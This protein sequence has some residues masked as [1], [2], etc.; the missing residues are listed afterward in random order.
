MITAIDTSVL[1]DVFL[2]DRK[3]VDG[4][5]RAIEMAA[6]D[7]LLVASGVVWAEVSAVFPEP[8]RAD[9][10]L[11]QAG[12]SYSPMGRHAALRA[13]AS[14]R[15][16]RQAGGTRN[17][18]IADFLIAGHAIENADRLLTRDRGFHRRYFAELVVLAP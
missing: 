18:M 14:W 3:F 1:L 13:G 9:D 16:Y 11:E 17:R 8:E 5:L 10:A 4:S 15:R 6:R 7:G 12:V 2:A